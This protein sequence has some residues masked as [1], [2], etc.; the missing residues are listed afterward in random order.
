LKTRVVYRE[1]LLGWLDLRTN[2]GVALYLGKCVDHMFARVFFFCG[3]KMRR[4]VTIRGNLIFML[5]GKRTLQCP[6]LSVPAA[7]CLVAR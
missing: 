1:D 5:V 2:E 4:V 6:V 7:G 3:E